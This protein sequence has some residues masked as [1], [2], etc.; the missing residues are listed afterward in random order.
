MADAL[1]FSLKVVITQKN[2]RHWRY[3]G[4]CWSLRRRRS[5]TEWKRLRQRSMKVSSS[6]LTSRLRSSTYKNN[7]RDFFNGRGK[8]FRNHLIYLFVR[9]FYLLLLNML[10][11]HTTFLLNKASQDRRRGILPPAMSNYCYGLRCV[12]YSIVSST[13]TNRTQFT[14]TNFSYR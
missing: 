3:G 8:I 12:N 11:Q 9:S 13:G 14:R 1:V 2:I 6:W 5:G 10:I 7:W 4:K